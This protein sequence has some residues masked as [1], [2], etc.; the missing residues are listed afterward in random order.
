LD[1]SKNS[2]FVD[3]IPSEQQV[4]DA[5]RTFEFPIIVLTRGLPDALDDVWPSADLQRI[6]QELQR[7]FL[8]LSPNSTQVIAER[9]GHLIQKDQPELVIEAI[10]KMLGR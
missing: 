10:C 2:E 1:P 4:R 8:Q 6:E 7:E 3:R 9:S 5:R